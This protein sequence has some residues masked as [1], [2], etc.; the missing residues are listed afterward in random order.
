MEAWRL[1]FPTG[2]LIRSSILLAACVSAQAQVTAAAGIAPGRTA[3]KV[4]VV[5]RVPGLSD[6]LDGF[7]A[8]LSYSSVHSSSAGWYSVTTPAVNYTF[9]RRFSADASTS[10]YFNRQVENTNAATA[11]AHPLVTDGVASGDT[12]IGFHAF[13]EPGSIQDTITASLTAP[14]GDRAKGLGVGQ[15]AYDFS[16]H[17]ERYFDQLGLVLDVGGGNSSGLFNDQVVKDYSSVGGLAHFES[18]LVYWLP[19]RSYI[20]AVAYEQLPLGSQTVYRTVARGDTARSEDEDGG[21][22]DPPTPTPPPVATTITTVAEDNGFTSF[23]G[24]PLNRHVILSGY[25]NRSLRQKFDTVSIGVTYILRGTPKKR[26]SMID[27]ALREAE[28]ASQK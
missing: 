22:G 13:F 3:E 9:S 4:Q 19:H 2:W 16:N 28:N 7:N 11:K 18:G 17:F 27:R 6:F 12:L 14:T 25:Y 21:G 8:G 26:M 10:I 5:P 15:V 20:E 1:F 23:V 24:V